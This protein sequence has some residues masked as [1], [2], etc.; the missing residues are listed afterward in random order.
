MSKEVNEGLFNCDEYTVVNTILKQ[1]AKYYHKKDIYQAISAAL[2]L[3]GW[4]LKKFD[5]HFCQYQDYFKYSRMM[6]YLQNVY[7]DFKDSGLDTLKELS[8][9]AMDK[10]KM[11]YIKHFPALSTDL[12][13]AKAIAKIYPNAT[14][15]EHIEEKIFRKVM[16]EVAV[17]I[18]SGNMATEIKTV[19]LN[20]LQTKPSDQFAEMPYYTEQQI[21]DIYNNLSSVFNS[22]EKAYQEYR[23]YTAKGISP[24]LAENGTKILQ[25]IN[26][27]SRS[28]NLNLN[29][30]KELTKLINKAYLKGKREYDDYQK[31]L[32]DDF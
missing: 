27:F 22:G 4:C 31:S 3:E 26:Q 25:D 29:Q 16:Q 15:S 6:T 20:K 8:Y 5:M 19:F 21:I 12:I 11:F 30:K 17:I 32:D 10:D 9:L 1:G 14:L 2:V 7:F 23:N 18:F 24:Q 28:C 13:S